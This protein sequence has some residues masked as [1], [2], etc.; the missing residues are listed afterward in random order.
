MVDGAIPY[1][2]VNRL[3]ASLAFAELRPNEQGEPGNSNAPA[4]SDRDQSHHVQATDILESWI[5]QN[6]HKRR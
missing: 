5:P 1:A 6:I 3:L 2:E 4:R